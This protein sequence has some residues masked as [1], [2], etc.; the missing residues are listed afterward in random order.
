MKLEP[1]HSLM[2]VSGHPI[3]PMLI[4]FPVAMLVAVMGTDIAWFL[5][6]DPFWARVGLW[7][8]GVGAL[9]VWV[10]SFVGLIDLVFVPRIRRLITAWTHASMAVIVLSLGTLNW[11]LRLEDP[12]ANILPWGL[13]VSLLTGA[14]IS[15]TSFL[16]GRLVFEFAVGI[17][18]EGA[19]EKQPPLS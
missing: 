9:G 1:I 10:S 16:G 19:A 17:D 13:Y 15:A 6:R 11:L 18:V 5:T 3:H 2:S 4:H 8:T 12:Q 7:L 14:L